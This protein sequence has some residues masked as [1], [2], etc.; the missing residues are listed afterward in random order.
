MSTTGGNIIHQRI[1]N[2]DIATP[3]P[4]KEQT[5]NSLTRRHRLS[6]A[7]KRDGLVINVD[8]PRIVK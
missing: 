8:L 6:T 3:P 5:L 4:Q 7:R 1:E 2:W